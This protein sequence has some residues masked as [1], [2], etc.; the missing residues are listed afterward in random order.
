MARIMRT[1]LVTNRVFGENISIRLQFLCLVV[2]Y[3]LNVDVAM[4]NKVNKLEFSLDNEL[5]L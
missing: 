4:A 5:G 2:S 1:I 3:E